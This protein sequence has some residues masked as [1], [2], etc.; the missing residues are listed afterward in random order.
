MAN[1]DNTAAKKR[2]P[3]L[4]CLRFFVFCF[5]LIQRFVAHKV[6]RTRLCPYIYRNTVR[7]VVLNDHILVVL[8]LK[9]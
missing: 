5:F 2:Q 3:H 6:A 1:N 9:F 8:E 4:C 7:V